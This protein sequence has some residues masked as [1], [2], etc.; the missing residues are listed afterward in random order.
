MNEKLKYYFKK[1]EN[2][3]T[4]GFDPRDYLPEHELHEDVKNI[5]KE[6]K[7]VTEEGDEAPKQSLLDFILKGNP[8]AAEEEEKEIEEEK[9]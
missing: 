4:L 8:N 7:K 6:D 1:A 2:K 3:P 9:K 5:G